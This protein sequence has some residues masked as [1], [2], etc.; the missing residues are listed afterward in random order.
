MTWSERQRE[1]VRTFLGSVQPS[2]P[3][4]LV[5]NIEEFMPAHWRAAFEAMFRA[6][7]PSIGELVER[8]SV[9]AGLRN[10]SENGVDAELADIAAEATRRSRGRSQS[11]TD[12][13]PPAST[14]SP[15]R[16]RAAKR[17]AR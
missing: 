12:A 11:R 3:A 16:R 5:S 4:L 9:G 14:T 15:R 2:N 1:A 10:I 17:R 13:A 6:L 7:A 8:S